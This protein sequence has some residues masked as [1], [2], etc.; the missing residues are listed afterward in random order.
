MGTGLGNGQSLLR[1]F[2]GLRMENVATATRYGDLRVFGSNR[3]KLIE[4]IGI[5]KCAEKG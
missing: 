1:L 4:T 5:V 3:V 2:D